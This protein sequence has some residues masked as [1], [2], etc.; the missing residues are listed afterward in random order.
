MGFVQKIIDFFFV[1]LEVTT[2]NGEFLVA[3]SGLRFYQIENVLNRAGNNSF[4]VARFNDSG[5]N[6]L[7][8]VLIL[9]PFHGEGLP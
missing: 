9:V 1:N 7:V 5:K 6:P 2:G 4:V 8:V 3:E